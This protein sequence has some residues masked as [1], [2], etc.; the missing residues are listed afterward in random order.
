MTPRLGI[1]ALEFE[2]C[3]K[4][5]FVAA[6]APATARH[7]KR[8]Q[9]MIDRRQIIRDSACWAVALSVGLA[10]ATTESEAQRG[11]PRDRDRPRD[12]NRRR[13]RRGP[14][15]GFNVGWGPKPRRHCWWSPSGRKHCDWW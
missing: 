8:L 7:T 15:W 12:R 11:P 5:S 13:R 6:G 1:P 14:R 2:Q 10:L 4:Y 3:Q 9:A